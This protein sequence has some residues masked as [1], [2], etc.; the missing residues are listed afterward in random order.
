M[1]S[2]IHD[3]SVNAVHPQADGALNEIVPEPPPGATVMPDGTIGLT[4][5]SAPLTVKLSNVDTQSSTAM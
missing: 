4:Q 2:A 3:A 1:V 5:R